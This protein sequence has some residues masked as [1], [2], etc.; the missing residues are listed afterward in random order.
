MKIYFNKEQFPETASKCYVNPRHSLHSC[1]EYIPSDEN[2]VVVG[3]SEA[4]QE[5]F[6]MFWDELG[7]HVSYLTMAILDSYGEYY[8][9]LLEESFEEQDDLEK[10]QFLRFFQVEGVDWLT[11]E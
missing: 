9:A 8:R 11:A 6:E 10:S 1:I 7:V 5:D 4:E 2:K 3:P